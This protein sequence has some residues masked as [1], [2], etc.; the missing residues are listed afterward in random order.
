VVREPARRGLVL[1]RLGLLTACAVVVASCAA[2]QAS[3]SSGSSGPLGAFTAH[4]ATMAP[5]SASSQPVELPPTVPA[6]STAQLQAQAQA[7]LAAVIAG[8]PAGS[9]SVAGFNVVTGASFTGGAT[10]GMWTAS[11]Y[12]LFV[13][14]T[15]LLQRQQQGTPL[16]SYE[17][18]EATPMI[19]QS[20][21]DA[22]Y[23]LFLAAGGNRGLAAAAKQFAMAST[24][25]GD[26]DPTFTTTSA[27][28]F[29]QLL[30]NLVTAGPLNAYS[31]SL[32]L[33]LMRGVE[34]DQRWGVGVV[35]DPGTT[36]ANKNG[37]LSVDN[38]NGSGEDDSSR[39]IVSS[40]GV[41]NVQGQQLLIS[42]FTEHQ[43]SMQA[44]VGL[45]QSLAQIVAPAI[46]APGR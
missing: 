45:V 37:W 44:G 6:V 10:A 38:S 15:L 17:L 30:K 7:K 35:A 18:G 2:P 36:F 1:R 26:S 42:V 19:E 32:A 20:D 12:K 40:V 21:N 34:A 28:D 39:W 8:Q 9:V 43:P 33:G 41:V 4:S 11:T 3:T 23:S 22:G 5:A 25:P 16:S 46:L 13:L 14:E 24:V 27:A 29:L 31:Q